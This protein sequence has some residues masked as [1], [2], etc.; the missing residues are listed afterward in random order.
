MWIDESD[1]AAFGDEMA[2]GAKGCQRPG[3][4]LADRTDVVGELL[5]AGP[6]EKV[7]ATLGV[8]G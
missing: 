8:R 4:D 1:D 2:V 7:L 3:D 5:V 6:N